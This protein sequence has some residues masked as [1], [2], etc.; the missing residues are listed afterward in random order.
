MLQMIHYPQEKCTYHRYWKKIL[1]S[2]ICP[3]ISCTYFPSQSYEK[4]SNIRRI[5]QNFPVNL[6]SF[7]IGIDNHAS[8][9]ISNIS[10]HLVG[11]ITPV[12]GKMVK[13][14]GGIV[15]ARGEGGIIWKIE[16]DD[17][18]IQT[19]RSIRHCIYLRRHHVCYPH[20][21]GH[22][23]QMKMIQILT[24]PGAPPRLVIV[25][26]IETRNTTV[27]PSPGIL[28]PM[29]L[30]SAQLHHQTPAESFLHPMKK[31]SS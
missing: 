28:H 31:S 9:I 12:K 19:T 24:V 17:G 13:Y 10:S 1:R 21:N 27:V 18:V 22:S 4:P 20:N 5:L 23:T 3:K 8:T 6:D 11:A 15:E 29:S 7:I 14:F 25:R 2:S 16:D 26:Y 30:E